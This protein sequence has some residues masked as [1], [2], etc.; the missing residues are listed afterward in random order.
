MTACSA[1]VPVVNGA[2]KDW[3]DALD[4]SGASPAWV[5][6][7]ILNGGSSSS[8]GASAL[9]E[10]VRAGS[11]TPVIIW[12]CSAVVTGEENGQIFSSSL[13]QNV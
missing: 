4:D 12:L 1:V 6:L 9:S 8:G 3:W 10:I 13:E 2:L 11:F 5:C 7:Q